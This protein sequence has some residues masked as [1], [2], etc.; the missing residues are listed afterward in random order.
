MFREH[1]TV[2]Y[3]PGFLLFVAVIFIAGAVF[4]STA[5]F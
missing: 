4:W 2:G 1:L 3:L 5:L